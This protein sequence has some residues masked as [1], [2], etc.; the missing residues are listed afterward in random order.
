MQKKTTRLETTRPQ[1]KVN[2]EAFK[3]LATEIGLNEACRKLDVPIPTGKSWA[4]RGGWKLPKRPGGRPGRTLTASSASSLHPISDALVAIHN[5][6]ETTTKT[7]LAR[8]TA[9]A[10]A[11]AS[12]QPP[13][14][15]CNPAQLRDLAASAAR[16]FGGTKGLRPPCKLMSLGSRR[17]NLNGCGSLATRTAHIRSPLLVKGTQP[18]QPRPRNEAMIENVTT[19]LQVNATSH[20]GL[21]NDRVLSTNV[22]R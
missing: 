18:L 5:E 1:T 11:H 10:A 8:A 19:A 13:L 6:L 22:G 12:T 3:M 7:A 16:V 15:V 14:E 2:K 20:R 9:A 17:G 21:N 4:R